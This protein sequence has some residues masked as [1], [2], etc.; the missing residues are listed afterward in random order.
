MKNN[1]TEKKK[2]VPVFETL[3]HRGANLTFI[4]NLHSY[5][6]FGRKQSNSEVLCQTPGGGVGGRWS[7][8]RGARRGLGPRVSLGNRALQLTL[9]LLPMGPQHTA[10]LGQIH[11]T[12]TFTSA[13]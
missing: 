7:Q 13:P 3:Y 5:N 9:H 2:I 1:L 10:L 11:T 4:L 12:S 6:I 8:S